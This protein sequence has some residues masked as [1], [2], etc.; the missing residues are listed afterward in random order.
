[1]MSKIQKLN[2]TH[3]TCITSQMAKML[4]M[5]S[6]IQNLNGTHNIAECCNRLFF[7]VCDVKDTKFEWNSQHNNHK[8]KQLQSCL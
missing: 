6:K 5:M 7:V 8:Q 1:M 4:F 3:N 2:G